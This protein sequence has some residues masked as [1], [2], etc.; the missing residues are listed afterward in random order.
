MTQKKDKLKE[1]LKNSWQVESD[2]GHK[3]ALKHKIEKLE[4]CQSE[5]EQLEYISGDW[6]TRQERTRT[7]IRT[8]WRPVWAAAFILLAVVIIL[9]PRETI[10]NDEMRDP[11]IQTASPYD[12][13]IKD[14]SAV[15]S[16]VTNTGKSPSNIHGTKMEA[17]FIYMFESYTFESKIRLKRDQVVSK[18]VQAGFNQP[19]ETR[20]VQVLEV[21]VPQEYKLEFRDGSTIYYDMPLEEKE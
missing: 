6:T 7:I 19:I 3:S 2:K 11:S 5:S 20:K 1:T 17:R 4:A 9:V 8:D 14:M 18:L 13:V 15:T 16:K 21:M 10:F 12:I